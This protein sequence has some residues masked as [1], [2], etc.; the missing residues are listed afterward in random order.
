MKH[1]HLPS[2]QY[3][4]M[5]LDVLSNALKALAEQSHQA[6][7]GLSVDE[8]RLLLLIRENTGISHQT[9]VHLSFM[10]KTK[11]SKLVS[12]LCRVQLVHRAIGANDARHIAL[13]LTPQGKRIAL[14]AHRY[15]IEATEALMQTVPAEQAKAFEAALEHLIGH[16]LHLHA[17]QQPLAPLS[18]KHAA[19]P[20]VINTEATHLP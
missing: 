19:H 6:L 15:V 1:P 10:E 2:A 11:V 4:T 20:P 14:K 16:V 3:L 17:T 9:L 12:A 13:S 8:V 18:K 5:R 7:Y